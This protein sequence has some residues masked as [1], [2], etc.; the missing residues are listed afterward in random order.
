VRLRKPQELLAKGLVL[1]LDFWRCRTQPCVPQPMAGKTL[2]ASRVA[3]AAALRAPSPFAV[4]LPL[5]G[6]PAAATRALLRALGGV[7]SGGLARGG[8][9][10]VTD[11]QGHAWR[12]VVGSAGSATLVSPVLEGAAGL[13]TLG[14]VV[15][16][17]RV[18]GIRPDEARAL[19]VD[20]DVADLD[21]AAL[22]RLRLLTARYAPLLFHALGVPEARRGAPPAALRPL[23]LRRYGAAQK[24]ALSRS[25][26][27]RWAACAPKD[28][29]SHGLD[30]S[31]LLATGFVSIA[32]GGGALHSGEVSALVQ[33]AVGLVHRARVGRAVTGSPR[34]FTEVT[35]RYDL[36]ILLLHLGFIG[37]DFAVQRE[38]LLR[39]IVGSAAWR[40]GRP[41]RAA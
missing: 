21:G 28:L 33:L 25:A 29:A 6:T 32:L 35:A 17:L 27:L 3:A 36:R 24:R 34:P 23:E 9:T 40:G 30:R 38:Q 20:V 19:A 31:G 2:Q 41:Q 37:V 15:R 10:V 22:E 1:T 13:A 18:D 12:L 14:A 39:R 7:L 8:P 4:T 11:A 16:A 26:A 5:L